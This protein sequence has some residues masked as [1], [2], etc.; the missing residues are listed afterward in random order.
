MATLSLARWEVRVTIPEINDG[1][2]QTA[3]FDSDEAALEARDRARDA[4]LTH[5]RARSDIVDGSI[6]KPRI[7]SN[8]LAIM[9]FT[10][11]ISLTGRSKR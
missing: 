6:G 5:L 8:A 4:F 1:D 9:H 11:P 7:G 2:M 3:H 10:N